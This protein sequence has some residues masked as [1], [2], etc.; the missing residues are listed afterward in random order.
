MIE[1]GVDRTIREGLDTR[2][3]CPG[4]SSPEHVR[5]IGKLNFNTSEQDVSQCSKCNRIFSK[6]DGGLKELLQEAEQKHPHDSVSFTSIVDGTNV[7]AND[8]MSNTANIPNF[9]NY[10]S[11]TNQELRNIKMNLDN[12]YNTLNS[13]LSNMKYSIDDLVETVR[14]L[15]TKNQDLQA[16]MMSDPLQGIRKSILDFDLK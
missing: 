2:P 4:C 13:N 6:V 14:D 9:D 5:T 8:T 10:N 7:I 1:L 11:A 3:R 12:S 16:K 15:A